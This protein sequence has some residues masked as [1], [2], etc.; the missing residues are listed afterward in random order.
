MADTI[1]AG[2]DIEEL[3]LDQCFAG[4]RFLDTE[5]SCLLK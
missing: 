5:L 2:K 4:F 3:A 1:F